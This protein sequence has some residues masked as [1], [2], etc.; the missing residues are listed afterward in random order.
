MNRKSRIDMISWDF[1]FVLTRFHD[2]W[3]LC[4]LDFTILTRFHEISFLCLPYFTRFRFCVDPISWDFVFVLTRFH[5]ILF[6]C[7]PDFTMLIRFHEIYSR[8]HRNFDF[9][10]NL[11]ATIHSQS[12]CVICLRWPNGKWLVPVNSK[13]SEFWIQWM[14]SYWYTAVLVGLL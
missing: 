10:Y 14:E 7:W 8:H 1:V 13:Y 3:F 5:E 12:V 6:L 9:C 11:S 2:T 4:W